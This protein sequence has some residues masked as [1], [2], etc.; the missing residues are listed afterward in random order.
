VSRRARSVRIITVDESIGKVFLN[1]GHRARPNEVAEIIVIWRALNHPIGFDMK[2]NWLLLSL[3]GAALLCGCD[4]QTR[5][6][7]EKIEI[8]SR[9][10]LQFE[11][12]HARQLAAIQ[13]QLTSLAPMLD[14]MNDYYFEKSHDEAFFFH[15]NTLYLVLMVDK[16][17][18]AQLQAADF[19]REAQN[20]QAYGYYTNQIGTLYLCT[21][22]IQ[23]ALTGQGKYITDSVNA[24][25]RQ[26]GAAVREELLEQIKL[27]APDDAEI[28]R[29][30]QVA[31]DV[32]QIKHDLEQ[33]KAQLGS[34]TNL[35]ASRP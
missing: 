23:D 20:S 15:T 11:Q 28:A 35:P 29:R 9:N 13:T 31:A 1:A 18:E 24:E 10:I 17:I 21:A 16:K 25:T 34:L 27:L 30:N 7:S 32:A 33:L 6:N 2:K 22:Q 14:K 8:L 5:I 12:G 26:V 3:T 4:K 19:E